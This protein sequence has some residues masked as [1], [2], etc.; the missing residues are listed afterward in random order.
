MATDP[1]IGGGS[2]Y[3]I[4]P[5]A[6]AELLRGP[7]GPVVRDMILRGERVKQEAIR[8]APIGTSS[9]PDKLGLEGRHAPGNL[10][11]HIVKRVAE[12]GKGI[13]VIVGVENVPYAIWVHEGSPPHD[14][15]PVRATRLVFFSER[16]GK[17]IYMPPGKPVHH[18][19]NK[20]NRFLIRAL[21][22][23]A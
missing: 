10:Q 18:P 8:I 5:V 11:R 6:L 3:V 20:P 9:G 14:I 15:Y 12:D 7:T 13:M 1:L 4:N 23:A 2:F 22:A 16:A 19:G 21:R 17:V